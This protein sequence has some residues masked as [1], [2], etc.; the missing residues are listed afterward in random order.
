V[1]GQ[2]PANWMGGQVALTPKKSFK[3]GTGPNML[4]R[5]QHFDGELGDGHYTWGA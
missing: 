4:C 2:G 5:E 1:P 3:I